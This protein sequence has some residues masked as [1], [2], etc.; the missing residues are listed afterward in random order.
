MNLTSLVILTLISFL[1][2][3]KAKGF[4]TNRALRNV[5]LINV[6]SMF[7]CEMQP[8][9]IPDQVAYSKRN[10]SFVI[11]F[12]TLYKMT[13]SGFI[14]VTKNSASVGFYMRLLSLMGHC[15]SYLS[16]C[17]FIRSFVLV[18]LKFIIAYDD[19]IVV[20]LNTII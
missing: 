9:Y 11:L 14:E 17:E 16:D 18:L 7:K 15:T 6:I 13:F 5:R 1:V 8:R 12:C 3:F 4:T 19:L 2:T 10:I 20:Q